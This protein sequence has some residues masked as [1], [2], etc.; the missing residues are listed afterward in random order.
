MLFSRK[1]PP[2]GFYVYF[3]LREDGTPYYVGKGKDKR[4]WLK[5]N[6]N[7]PKDETRISFIAINLMESEAHLLEIKLISEYGRKDLRTGILRNLTN[8]GEGASG[9]KPSKETIDKIKKSSSYHAK[10]SVED[11]T[12]S[13]LKNDDGSSVASKMAEEGKLHFQKD[14]EAASY[15]SRVTNRKRIEDGNH[16][17]QD[18]EAATERNKKKVEDGTHNFIGKGIITLVDKQGI[19]RRLPSE[20]LT[21]WKQSGLPMSEWDYVGSRSKEAKRRLTSKNQSS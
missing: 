18:K 6:V 16:N 15:W 7:L 3:Y 19:G 5:H 8:G 11:G 13:F 2:P 12:N 14:P 1:N 9:R 17:F 20:I 10:K 4:A 21:H